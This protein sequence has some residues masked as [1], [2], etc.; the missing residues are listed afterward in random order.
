[1]AGRGLRTVNSQEHPGVIK[2]N[3]I[4]LDFGTASLTHGSLEQNVELDGFETTE[5]FLTMTCPSCEAEIPLS[6]A[7][8]PICGHYFREEREAKKVELISSVQMMEINL[9]NRSSFE[10]VDLFDDN[11]AFVSTGFDAWGGVFRLNG[12]WHSIG[13]KKDVSP[14]I[15]AVG[16]RIVCLAAADDW[17]NEHET[18]EAAHKSR[19]WLQEL[20]TEKQISLLSDELKLDFNLTRYQASAHITFRMNKKTIKEI[21]EKSVAAQNQNTIL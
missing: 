20:P 10:W 8:C 21:V 6:S 4:I 5:K 1:M 14:S 7:E 3:C 12:M 9:L 19:V 13:G 18:E 11:S 15:L 16:E 2:N 17:L